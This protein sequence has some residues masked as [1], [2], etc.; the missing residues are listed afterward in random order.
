[1]AQAV[2]AFEIVVGSNDRPVQSRLI[3]NL[4]LHPSAQPQL[5]EDEP[6]I[7]RFVTSVYGAVTIGADGTAGVR[8][9]SGAQQLA[10][11][12]ECAGVVVF[13]DRRVVGALALGEFFGMRLD[14]DRDHRAV[15]MSLDYSELDSMELLSRKR[16]LGGRSPVGIQLSV[17]RPAMA[18]LRLDVVGETTLELASSQVVDLPARFNTI[19][20]AICDNRLTLASGATADVLRRTR[21]GEYERSENGDPVAVFQ[22]E[23]AP[24]E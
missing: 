1:M 20:A 11:T 4:L 7:A 5:T 22:L 10:K 14:H 2:P 17:V 12:G 24:N 9:E 18:G 8:E 21:A 15:M 6:E 3:P 23:E 16:M 19:V 13:T